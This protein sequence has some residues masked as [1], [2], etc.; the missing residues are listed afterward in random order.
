MP[1][2]TP[3]LVVVRQTCCRGVAQSDTDE[4][5]DWLSEAH[6]L[7]RQWEARRGGALLSVADAAILAETIARGLQGAFER[8]RTS[9]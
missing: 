5:F 6:V 4:W 2:G 9:R 7:V 1:G 8:G 3:A